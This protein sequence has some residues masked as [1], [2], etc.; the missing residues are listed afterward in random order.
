MSSLNP[1]YYDFYQRLGESKKVFNIPVVE[2]FFGVGIFFFLMLKG[3]LLFGILLSISFLVLLGIIKQGKGP[4][5][6]IVLSYWYL[7]DFVLPLCF[8]KVLSVTPLSYQRVWL[9]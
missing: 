8:F 1:L 7:P 2:F 5:W 4:K 6:L 3:H 9:S